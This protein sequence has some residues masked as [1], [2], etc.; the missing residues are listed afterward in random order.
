MTGADQF[1]IVL[2]CAS[3]GAA[4]GIAYDF[5]YLV[6]RFFPSRA[7]DIVCDVAFFLVFAGIYL[8]VSLLF[9]L[10]DF[11]IYMFLAC[12][13]GLI[14]YLKSWHGIVAFFAEKVYNKVVKRGRMSALQRN[15][16]KKIC[17]ISRKRRKESS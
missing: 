2:V 15:T 6:R 11:R 3:C 13:A 16:E 4:G 9:A 10:P 8:F 17:R 14:L 5:F 1:Y 12:L 7:T